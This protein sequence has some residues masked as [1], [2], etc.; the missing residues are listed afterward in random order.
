VRTAQCLEVSAGTEDAS[1]AVQD[2]HRGVVV[3]VEG[4][5]GFG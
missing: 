1:S 5:E 2:G 3:G 4:P